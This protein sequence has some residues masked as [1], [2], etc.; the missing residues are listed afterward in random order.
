M[1]M[2]SRITTDSCPYTPSGTQ[3]NA[4]GCTDTDGDGVKDASDNCPLVSNA[5]QANADGDNFGNA[6]D[7]DY[8]APIPVMGVGSVVLTSIVHSFAVSLVAS[9]YADGPCP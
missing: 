6:C 1:V 7:G 3:V 8:V 2:A 9:P 5:D 4:S